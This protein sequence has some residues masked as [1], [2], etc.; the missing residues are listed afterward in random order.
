MREDSRWD[1]YDTPH[2]VN[3]VHMALSVRTPHRWS[4]Q[5]VTA[6]VQGELLRGRAVPGTVMPTTKVQYLSLFLLLYINKTG[7]EHKTSPVHFTT[8]KTL[9]VL[10]C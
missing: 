2:G 10:D 5:V 1:A 9:T 4:E 6:S 3:A 8:F 7:D